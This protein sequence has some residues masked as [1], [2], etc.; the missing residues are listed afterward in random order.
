ML[1]GGNCG[2]VEPA[3]AIEAWAE[4]RPQQVRRS[5][6]L[7]AELE[8]TSPDLAMLAVANRQLKSMVG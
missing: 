7:L 8:T 4:T 2:K 1:D 5:D 3:K 6:Q